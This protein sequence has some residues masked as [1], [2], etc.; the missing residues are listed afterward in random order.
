M[1]QKF[2]LTQNFLAK[3]S[4]R[5]TRLV[6]RICQRCLAGPWHGASTWHHST[7]SFQQKPSAFWLTKSIQRNCPCMRYQYRSRKAN[8]HKYNQ[9]TDALHIFFSR[10]ARL[11]WQ[12]QWWSEV[13]QSRHVYACRFHPN[14][15]P[16]FQEDPHVTLVDFH[17]CAVWIHC[18]TCFDKS[19]LKHTGL[20]HDCNLHNLLLKTPSFNGSSCFDCV[21]TQHT[22][23]P[24][25]SIFLFLRAAT[26]L[27]EFKQWNNSLSLGGVCL[28]DNIRRCSRS[29][30][31]FS[32]GR[33]CTWDFQPGWPFG[34]PRNWSLKGVPSITVSG[35][36]EILTSGVPGPSR[37][38]QA[39]KFNEC[40]HAHTIFNVHSGR[41]V[42]CK[43]GAPCAT[44]MEA[45]WSNR[46]IR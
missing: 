4:G 30:K 16:R 3:R 14:H 9:W 39:G 37:F 41:N 45:F 38:N 22:R 42:S 34:G 29:P 7:R 23:K 25:T 1:V 19:D 11:G 43:K 6:L 44:T 21:L 13:I 18:E 5:K 33:L 27:S 35:N 2:R 15:G 17:H 36:V 20:E 28:H 40:Q 8:C 46:K 12:W 26:D 31:Q 10:T 24:R 32:F